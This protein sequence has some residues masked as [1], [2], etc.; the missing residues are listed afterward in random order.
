MELYPKNIIQSSMKIL[1]ASLSLHL[2]SLNLLFFLHQ[3]PLRLK[4]NQVNIPIIFP[5][6]IKASNLQVRIHFLIPL[7]LKGNFLSDN[8]KSDDVV[9]GKV[10]DDEEPTR[11]QSN[12]VAEMMM[13][14]W[15]CGMTRWHRI[16][17]DDIGESW[18]TPIVEKMIEIRLRWFDVDFVARRVNQMEGSQI[19][20]GVGRPRQTIRKTVRNNIEINEFEKGMIFDKTL[21]RRLIHVSDAT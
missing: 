21:W 10:L 7:K 3:L 17:N 13:L 19:T 1:I 12:S 20:R 9:R 4:P 5:I 18:I 15:M 2:T 6:H 14:R 16:R 11:I 8:C